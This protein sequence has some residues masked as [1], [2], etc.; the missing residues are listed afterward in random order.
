MKL[1]GEERFQEY[2]VVF[3]AAMMVDAAR[4]LVLM[5]MTLAFRLV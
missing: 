5:G 2:S 3:V 1:P 4:L